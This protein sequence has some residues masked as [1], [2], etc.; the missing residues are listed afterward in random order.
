MVG[1]RGIGGL[2]HHRDCLQCLSCSN[3]PVDKPCSTTNTCQQNEV[4][5]VEKFETPTNYSRQCACGPFGC[6]GCGWVL[7][8]ETRLDMGCAQRQ[9]CSTTHTGVVGKRA[10]HVSP[11]HRLMCRDCCTQSDNC[12]SAQ[13][14]CQV[15]PTESPDSCLSCVGV[16][17]PKDCA[18]FSSCKH[19]DEITF[20]NAAK[21]T[22]IIQ[23]CLHSNTNGISF[24]RRGSG[25]RILCERCCSGKANCNF[26]LSC[27]HTNNI[28]M[29]TKVEHSSCTFTNE[30]PG[31]LV[32][33]SGHC[34]CVSSTY[35]WSGKTCLSQKTLNDEC[36]SLKECREGMPCH[37]RRCRQVIQ[38]RN[39]MKVN[40]NKN[41]NEYKAGF[42][43]AST[44][45]WLG[46]ENIHLISSNGHHMLR[47]DMSDKR[48]N[49]AYAQYSTFRVDDENSQYNVTVSGYSGTAGDSLL[50]ECSVCHSTSGMGFTTRDRDNDAYN[51]G[52]CGKRYS[53]GW[54]YTN[55]RHAGLNDFYS[56]GL[57]WY[58]WPYYGI[59]VESSMIMIG[60]I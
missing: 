3:I 19:A 40:F 56:S 51:P 54:W 57:E 4:C 22:F 12:N 26:D 6:S 17:N 32:C 31:N 35:Y 23:V 27:D 29:G 46:N 42:G 41:W 5:Y 28:H 24:G 20:A 30:C 49:S 8:Y 59:M 60:R 39:V 16:I 7:G 2:E 1:Q 33:K 37:G 21:Q 55:C 43:S 11:E 15:K 10:I 34:E 14:S 48:G 36:R 50:I 25:K 38:K 13:N 44:E 52:N 47:I 9:L 53:G 18:E 58:T 45:Y